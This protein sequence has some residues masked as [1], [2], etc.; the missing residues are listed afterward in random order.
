MSRDPR[1]AFDLSGEIA[2]VT[3]GGTGLG[4]AIA[5]CFAAA[6]ARVVIVGRR[7][8]VLAQAAAGIG[9]R[10]H[11]LA[12][13]ITDTAR[14]VE[15]IDAAEAVAQGP[16]SILVNNAGVHLK[17]PAIATSDA[18]FATVM[19]THVAAAFSLSRECGRRMTARGRGSILFTSSMAAMMGLPLVVA[20]SAAK[21]AYTGLVR[22]LAAEY[23]PHGVRVNAIAPGWIASPMLDAALAGDPQRRAKILSR[24][25][26]GRFGEPNDIG[27]AA[28]YLSSPAA[29]FV[30]GTILTV[31]GGAAAGF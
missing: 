24:T 29:N 28:V 22:T 21:S 3:G 18:E 27:W 26:L 25:P 16:I 19:Q 13:D 12:R 1:A 6:G 9:E 30:T 20:Y 8:E 4:L 31:D 15:V 7:E 17:K 5:G 2:L 10:A 23:G 14:C 11:Y